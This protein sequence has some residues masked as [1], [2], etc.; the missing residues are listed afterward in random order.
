MAEENQIKSDNTPP[1]AE[2]APE[3]KVIKVPPRISVKDLAGLLVLPV[4]EVIASLMKNGVLAS[5]NENVDFDT[6][7]IIADDLGFE[8]TL[9][10]EKE[11]AEGQ[12]YKEIIGHEEKKNL[13]SRP[14]IVV[15]LGHVDH[16]KTLLLDAIRQTKVV[17]SE[18]GGIT[19]RIGAYQVKH[20]NQYIT[21]IDTPGHEAFTAMRSRG[22][23]VADIAILVVAAD[24]GIKPQ[25][26]EALNIIK[27][28]GLPLIVAINKIDK[29]ESD[30]DRVMRELADLDLLSEE[31]GGKTIVAKVSAKEKKG[32]DE[33]LEMILLVYEMEKQKI[34]ANP[35]GSVIA[36]V[37]ES[38][39]DPQEGATA[40][41]IIHTG[42]LKISELVAIGD[43]YGKI[44]AMKNFLG[45]AVRE[46][47]PSTPVKIYGLKGSPVV[48][49]ILTV[50][51]DL[52]QYKKQAKQ[53][54]L[55]KHLIKPTES[56]IETKKEKEERMKEGKGERKVKELKIILKADNLG[57]LEAISESLKKFQHPEVKLEIVYSGLGNIMDSDIS[58]AEAT[59]ALLRG[60]NVSLTS[61]AEDLAREK[62]VV[63]KSYKIIYELFDEIKSKLEG[64]LS[65]D[66]FEEKTGRMK[67]LAIFR[68]EKK[69]MI[70]GGK[71]TE[72]KFRPK[73]KVKV[74]RDKVEIGRGTISQTQQD[75]K[76]V[77]EVGKGQEAGV[78]FEGEPVIAVNDVI[79]AYEE[80]KIFKK[81]QIK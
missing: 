18:Y 25:T 4:T 49:D 81:I 53:Y 34:L 72:G 51:K 57:S 38:H 77:P 29:P 24:D 48:G 30:I 74:L 76:A 27:T 14:P 32:I 73:A 9:K 26:K 60:F 59:D 54:R 20:K 23:K 33:L 40:T 8:A 63:F 45:E 15:V 65:P 78:K 12:D 21:F 61:S 28:A 66:I 56:R 69:S 13:K 37:V 36:S 79:E 19:Q 10:E 44:K 35:N 11:V 47:S 31:W 17:D 55:D 71:V 1:V 68:T 50:V 58:K 6:A 80:Q 2:I 42:T 22:A 52:S 5:Q 41:V 64:M 75:K 7:A 16:G 39:I 67:V 70:V 62:K 46:A 3:K 43:V